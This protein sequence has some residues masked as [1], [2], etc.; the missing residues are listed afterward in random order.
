MEKK[1]FFNICTRNNMCLGYCIQGGL[2]KIIFGGGV[3]SMPLLFV[4]R[5]LFYYKI[6]IVEYNI[7]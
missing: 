7:L 3:L 2:I 4:F 6:E 5:M 1:F